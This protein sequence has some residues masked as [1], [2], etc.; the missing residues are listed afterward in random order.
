MR[1]DHRDHHVVKF[2]VLLLAQA[3]VHRPSADDGVHGV[4]ARLS[5]TWDWLPARQRENSPGCRAPGQMPEHQHP[6]GE[7]QAAGE[8]GAGDGWEHDD[9]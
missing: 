9:E 7:D 5:R 3:L 1:G 4:P 8:E 6:G 2:A